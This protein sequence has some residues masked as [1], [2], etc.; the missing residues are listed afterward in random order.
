MREL[1]DFQCLVKI[2]A[3]IPALKA[4]DVPHAEGFNCDVTA[5]TGRL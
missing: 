4:S 2:A 3:G 5:A 1:C